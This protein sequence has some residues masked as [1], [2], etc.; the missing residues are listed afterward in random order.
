MNDAPMAE[1]IVPRTLYI[2]LTDMMSA[3]GI[4]LPLVFFLIAGVIALMSGAEQGMGFLGV[5]AVAAVIGFPVAAWRIY[6]IK[7]TLATGVEVDGVV[8][9]VKLGGRSSGNTRIKWDYQY[10]GKRYQGEA[11]VSDSGPV[12]APQ[13]GK[14]IHLWVNP[15]QPQWSVWQDLYTTPLALGKA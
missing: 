15:R 4:I 10:E 3:A 8:T 14:R 9:F 5:G 12:R 11:Y 1:R 13:K 2:A 6:H 7:Q